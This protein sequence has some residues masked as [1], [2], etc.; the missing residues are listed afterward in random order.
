MN[1]P[2][3]PGPDRRGSLTA[4]A[5]HGDPPFDWS[6]VTSASQI[7]FPQRNTYPAQLAGQSLASGRRVLLIYGGMH[8]STRPT[9]GPSPG[10]SSRRPGPGPT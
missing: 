6:T 10:S 1:A 8:C 2:N 9:G 7:P 5:W 4:P 3:V